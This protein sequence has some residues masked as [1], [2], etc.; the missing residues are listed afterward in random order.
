M[1][2]SNRIKQIREAKRIKQVEISNA[3]EMNNSY[4]ARLEKRGSKLTL[5]QI[6]KIA[7][8]LGVSVVEL[9]G[10]DAPKIVE[11]I[12]IVNNS[13]KDNEIGELKKRVVELED[14]INDKDLRVELYSETI[15]ELV[16]ML[17][18]VFE[19]N[20][21]DCAN[22]QKLGIIEWTF[23]IN[24]KF[25]ERVNFNLK[26]Y[27]RQSVH[28]GYTTNK[29][30]LERTQIKGDVIDELTVQKHLILSISDLEKIFT[31]MWEDE[32]FFEGIL[33]DVLIYFP[34]NYIKQMSSL[35]GELLDLMFNLRENV[36]TAHK[37]ITQIYDVKNSRISNFITGFTYFKL[38][39]KHPENIMKISHIRKDISTRIQDYLVIRDKL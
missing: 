31:E 4:Y 3:L 24:Y 22:N 25:I 8:A 12:V 5:E 7:G 28:I 10:L 21:I 18:K 9:L 29:E 11:P 34:E 39:E 15:Y 38:L 26:N 19:S 36:E 35:N 23:D 20:I 16:E 33:D 27:K 6:E 17:K 32:N 30:D 13:E 1:D 2:I 14:R 37:I